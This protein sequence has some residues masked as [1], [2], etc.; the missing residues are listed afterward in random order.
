MKEI[1]KENNKRILL[2]DDEPYILR[3]LQLKLENAGY[4]VLTAVNGL[5]AMEKFVRNEPV[6]VITDIQMPHMNGLEL[7]QIMQEQREKDSFLIII[8]TSSVDIEAHAR[9]ENM[10][11]VH[12]I[13]KPLSPRNMLNIVNEYFSKLQD[14]NVKL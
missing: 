4:E 11:G 1:N 9:D 12:F 7:C 3:V 10:A 2:V 6:V 13:E 8:M 14:T 5:D